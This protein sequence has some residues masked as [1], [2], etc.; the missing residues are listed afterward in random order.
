[1]DGQIQL[2]SGMK[3]PSAVQGQRERLWRRDQNPA[4]KGDLV[5]SCWKLS[6]FWYWDVMLAVNPWIQA[7]IG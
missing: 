4:K 2:G 7:V 3:S 5:R 1:M 6:S